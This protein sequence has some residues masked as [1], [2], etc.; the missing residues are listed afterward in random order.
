MERKWTKIFSIGACIFLVGCS[1]TKNIPEGDKLYTGARVELKGTTE[2][3]RRE[4]KVLKADLEG[5]TRPKPNT[6]FLGIPIKLNLYNLFLQEQ[7]FA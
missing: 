3:T 2:L 4:H 6:R 1:A 7:T 5:L